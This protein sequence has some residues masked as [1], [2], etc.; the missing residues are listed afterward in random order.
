ME[1]HMDAQDANFEAITSY[2]TESLV[3]VCNEMDANHAAKITRINHMISAQND[4][5]SSLY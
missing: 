5:P 3:S 2:V 4:K 1:E